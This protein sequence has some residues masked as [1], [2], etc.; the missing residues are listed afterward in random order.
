[1]DTSFSWSIVSAAWDY[2]IALAFTLFL[3]DIAGDKICI[4]GF[5]R[6]G[7]QNMVTISLCHTECYCS[8]HR[9]SPGWNG[10]EGQTM[11]IFPLN[12][13]VLNIECRSACFPPATSSKFRSPTTCSAR[14]TVIPWLYAVTSS[15]PTVS[16]SRSSS[17][18]FGKYTLVR[19]NGS[20]SNILRRDTVASVGIIP[21]YLPFVSTNNSIRFFRHAV[22]LDEHRVCSPL[23]YTSSC[24]IVRISRPSLCPISTR[25]RET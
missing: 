11:T 10:A 4:F 13:R 2:Y 14:K 6:G 24:L 22:A 23:R 15:V 17:V 5:S 16:M 21:R 19:K 12:G 3:A 7:E 8:I 9:A 1:M 25:T 18:V 20:A